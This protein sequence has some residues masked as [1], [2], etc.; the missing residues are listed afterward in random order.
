MRT[1][2]TGMRLQRPRRVAV[3]AAG[4]LVLGLL[5]VPTLDTVRATPAAAA[6]GDVGS[7]TGAATAFVADTGTGRYR[8]RIVWVNWGTAGVKLA[9]GGTTTVR[10]WQEITDRSRIEVT[11][12]MERGAGQD[13]DVYRA[14]TWRADGLDNLYGRT[15]GNQI[16]SGFRA[17]EGLNRT[18]DVGCT[19]AYVTYTGA[20]FSGTATSMPIALEGLVLAD[21]ESTH[22][23][24]RLL[25]MPL[26]APAARWHIIERF[27]GTCG[28]SY[29]ALVDSQTQLVLQ[30]Q[31]EC[32]GNGG[33]ATA[34]A[35]VEGATRLRVTLDSTGGMSA[36]A[37]GYIL[38]ADY[39]DA[40]AAA[41]GIAPAVV[42]PTWAAGTALTS[43]PV[44][45]IP[46]GF[47]LSQMAP[48]TV[49]LG[50]QAFAN[51]RLPASGN[52]LGD[53]G[54]TP[55]GGAIIA[56]EDAL[57]APVRINVEAGVARSYQLTVPCSGT[58]GTAV[59]GWVDWDGNGQFGDAE[60]SDVVSCTSPG[61]T[62]T[63][64]WTSVTV[65][66]TAVGDRRLRLAIGTGA[67]FATPTTPILAGE[68]EDWPVTFVVPPVRVTKTATV[69]TMPD[70]GAT[71]TYTVTVTNTSGSQRAVAVLDDYRGVWD[72]ATIGTSTVSAGPQA[73]NDTTN[74]QIRWQP[75]VPGNASRTL[76]YTV[77]VRAGYPGDRVMTNVV[78][79]YD[80][81]PTAGTA[82]TC[83][84]GSAD[85]AIGV[86][87]RVDLHRPALTVD[88]QA[89]LATDTALA[90]PLPDAVVLAPG[91]D[92]VWRYVV[93]NT[94]TTVVEGVTIGDAATEVRTTAA[95][96]VTTT[97]PPVLTC[98]DESPATTVNLGTL[99]PGE[100][101]TC[102]AAG[103]VVPP[104]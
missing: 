16:V 82:V 47:Q 95:G 35:F 13:V 96:T 93:T 85:H 44:N 59:A 42:Q 1:E 80:T 88:K 52:A 104:P 15:S 31:V 62:V 67:T 79:W 54:W 71:V 8:D 97:V 32:S 70:A 78:R 26:D 4:A 73:T 83:T 101:R 74:R 2:S 41:Y 84:S 61:A 30:G 36:G 18:V 72:D 7:T 57:T 91:T 56:D 10:Q 100:S 55:T 86:C 53:T 49:R 50:A 21:P 11:C 38:G 45:V 29:N 68:V 6:V 76:T 27:A 75:T 24:E 28:G 102:T 87:A 3:A 20:Q 5:V 51:L 48:P 12:T 81:M 19:A 98:G 58:A 66:A 64:T 103:T 99:A 90:T 60:R 25:A 43:S 40:A 94:G 23:Q 46:A 34:V 89:Y 9:A 65:P 17:P 37:I 92:V 63:L 22:Q 69:T 77:T 39:G 33:S 14:G